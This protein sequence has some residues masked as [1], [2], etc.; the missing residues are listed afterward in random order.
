[1]LAGLAL[2][3]LPSAASGRGAETHVLSPNAS[4]TTTVKLDPDDPLDVTM[5]GTFTSSEA[6]SSQKPCQYDA[7]YVWGCFP[8]PVSPSTVF[9]GLEIDSYAP[10]QLRRVSDPGTGRPPPYRADHRYS[11]KLHCEVGADTCGRVRFYGGFDRSSGKKWT[12]A[13]TVELGGDQTPAGVRVD[14]SFVVTGKPNLVIRKVGADPNVVGSRLVGS[15][16]V[17]FTKR[18]GN[19]LVGTESK[20]SIVHEDVLRGGRRVR[21]ELGIITGVKGQALG[22]TY[23]HATGRLS[24]LLKVKGSNDARCEESGLLTPTLAGA[25]LI[26]IGGARDELVFFGYPATSGTNACGGHAHAWSNGF[27]GVTVRMK[28][29]ETKA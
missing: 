10:Q 19:L 2:L 14:F 17:T 25:I 28:I 22:S 1:M 20:G 12:G 3:L 27:G 29:T 7:F 8:T 6:G 26:P 23:S 16:H 13:M 24:L 15:G 11:F 9:V 4:F 5:S 18:Q 21:L